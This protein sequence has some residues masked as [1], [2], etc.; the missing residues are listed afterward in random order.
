[1]PDETVTAGDLDWLR[2][3]LEDI[4]EATREETE[5]FRAANDAYAADYDH[6]PLAERIKHELPHPRRD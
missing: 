3:H 5:E 1:M 6:A 4:A 2:E